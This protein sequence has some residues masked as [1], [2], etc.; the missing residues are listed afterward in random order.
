MS[1][2]LHDIK[3]SPSEKGLS[4]SSFLKTDLAMTD[5]MTGMSVGSGGDAQELHE[6]NQRR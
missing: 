1:V 2:G 5:T 3:K 6:R 4:A